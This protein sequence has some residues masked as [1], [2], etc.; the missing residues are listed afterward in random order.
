MNKH[1]LMYDN[2]DGNISNQGWVLRA[3]DGVDHQ[4]ATKDRNNEAGAMVE[5]QDILDREG[6]EGT[7]EVVS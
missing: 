7:I 6:L 5:A 3:N 4:L 2:A 1:E